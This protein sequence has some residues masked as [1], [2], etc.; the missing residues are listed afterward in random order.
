VYMGIRVWID[1]VCCD[2]DA[3]DPMDGFCCWY[4]AMIRSSG[5]Y[6][7]RYSISLRNHG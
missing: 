6:T 5:I 3:D 4:D 1:G 7:Q 2:E